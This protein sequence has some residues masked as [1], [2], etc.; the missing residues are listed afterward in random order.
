MYLHHN[1]IFPPN[2][3]RD[4]NL[5]LEDSKIFLDWVVSHKINIV[6]FGHVHTDFYDVLPLK[7]L[8]KLLPYKRLRVFPQLRRM[9]LKTN[10]LM[11]YSQLEIGGKYLRQLDCL[12]YQYAAIQ[13]K[14]NPSAAALLSPS[15]FKKKEELENYIRDLPEYASFLSDLKNLS[16]QETA[17]IMAGTTCQ[18]NKERINSYL[19]IELTNNLSKLIV[20]RH[21]YKYQ[22][23]TFETKQTTFDI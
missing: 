7:S 4:W 19:E 1:P 8:L 11:D 15:N 3:K 12:V 20:Y 23:S 18:Y 16:N 5:I 9:Q 10:A 22:T 17:F 21:K 2:V 14:E 13:R 6:M